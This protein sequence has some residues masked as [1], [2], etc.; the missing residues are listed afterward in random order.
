MGSYIANVGPRNMIG[1]KRHTVK[2]VDYDPGWASRYEAEADAVRRAVGDLIVDVQHVG[3]T[4][5]QDLCAKPIVDIAVAVNTFNVMGTLVGCLTSIGYIDRA[6]GGRDGG[7]LLVRD[8]NPEVRTVHLHVVEQSDTQWTN[9]IAF[10]DILRRDSS[11]REQYSELKRQL[12]IRFPNDRKSY[13]DNKNVFIQEVLS[14]NIEA[15]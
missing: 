7:Y 6:D 13:T 10:R 12:A 8:S 14:K 2:V 11:I 3:S 9:Y 1:L 5:V 15:Q 4:A